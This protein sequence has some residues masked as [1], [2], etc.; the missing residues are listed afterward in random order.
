MAN[1]AIEATDHFGLGANFHPQTSS[2]ATSFDR[3]NIKDEKGNF[4]CEKMTGER[5]EYSATYRYCNDSSPDIASDLGEALTDFGFAEGMFVT[6]MSINFSDGEYAEVTMNGIAYADGMPSDGTNSVANVSACV[7]EGAGFGVPTLAGV[8][9]GDDAAPVSL[10][11]NI[12]NNHIMAMDGNGDF[13]VG[14][15]IGFL[16]EADAEYTGIPSS[17]DAPTGWTTDSITQ[18]DNNENFDTASWSGHRYFDKA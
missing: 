18:S 13:F 8:N 16:A 12:S 5:T 9:T 2:A 11:I 4:E 17:Y 15:N 6:S 1:V 3:K 7:P 14:T 10:N